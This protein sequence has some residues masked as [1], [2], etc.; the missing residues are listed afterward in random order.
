[1]SEEKSIPPD[2]QLANKEPANETILPGG[3]VASPADPIAET[4]QTQP[5]H[6]KHL[7]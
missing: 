1:M 5:L 4:E 2:E 3:Q 7:T 6:T